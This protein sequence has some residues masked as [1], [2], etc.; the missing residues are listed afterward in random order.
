MYGKK[1]VITILT[2]LIASIIQASTVAESAG[3]DVGSTSWQL[4][5]VG[6]F[7]MKVPDSWRL[8]G[9][10]EIDKIRAFYEEQARTIYSQYNNGAQSPQSNVSMKAYYYGGGDGL[11]AI[12]SMDVPSQADLISTLKKEADEKG[13]WGERN[14]HI[15]KYYGKKPIESESCSGFYV[16]MLDSSGALSLS[17]GLEH[18]HKR[19]TVIQLTMTCP[20]DMKKEQ[21]ISQLNQIIDSIS[22]D[23]ERVRELKPVPTPTA[24]QKRNGVTSL[25][26][27]SEMGDAST[28]RRLV[29]AGT[30]PNPVRISDGATALC[31]AAQQG[32]SEVVKVLLEAGADP[33]I[34][35][36]SDGSVPLYCAAMNGHSETVSALLSGKAIVDPKNAKGITP[37]WIA[38]QEGHVDVVKVL[39]K[40]GADL[41][42]KA[43]KE[44]TTPLVQ[45]AQ[46]GHLGVV[47]ALV[48]NGAQID[49][50]RGDGIT[51]L[52]IAAFNGRENIVRYLLKSGADRKKTVTSGPAR[53]MTAAD[54]AK[55]KGYSRITNLLN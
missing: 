36:S 43:K 15:K 2:I 9:K 24:E 5:V 31:Q 28:V 33:T 50:A 26:L 32:H 17:A 49:L 42:H 12:V 45:A 29:S 34:G 46:Q 7:A 35:R 47:E 8:C 41:N 6:E 20:K 53:G 30:D 18:N 25:W 38:A 23:E 11:L 37:L 51:P 55:H 1:C 39:A 4:V 16:T 44:R 48:T 3:E 54:L 13:R 10:T 19:N 52:M 14:G 27:A 40:N 21:A 22:L